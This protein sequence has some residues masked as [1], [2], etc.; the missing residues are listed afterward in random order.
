MKLGILV[1]FIVAIGITIA[2]NIYSIALPN[3][4]LMNPSLF[5]TSLFNTSLFNTSLLNTSLFNTINVWVIL[6]YFVFH[7]ALIKGSLVFLKDYKPRGTKELDNSNT[8]SILVGFSVMNAIAEELIFRNY[9]QPKTNIIVQA[10][11][12]SVYHMYPLQNTI[13]LVIQGL[14]FGHMM[15][16][17]KI[18]VPMGVH[19]LMNLTM[20]TVYIVNR[21]LRR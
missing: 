7:M 19:M 10:V 2:D 13:L 3:T 8:P 15:N 18:L 1:K 21:Y 9:F 17:H 11:V 5:N 4:S 20:G 12:F 6:K 14:S 16:Q